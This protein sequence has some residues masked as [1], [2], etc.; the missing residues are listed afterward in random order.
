MTTKDRTMDLRE[1]R[2]MI[3]D[4]DPIC[5]AAMANDIE[6]LAGRVLEAGGAEEA[7]AYLK[8]GHRVDAFLLDVHLD[9][10]D[11]LSLLR[12]IKALPAY[13]HTPAVLVTS[14]QRNSSI[15][16]GVR[17]G[18]YF[19]LTKPTGSALL[20]AVLGAALDHARDRSQ[21]I[22]AL[23]RSHRAATLMESG[24]FVLRS[25][26]EAAALAQ[27]LAAVCP[28]P[29]AAS[30][31]LHELLINAVEHGNLGIDY[32]TKTRL[33]LQ[34]DWRN[35]VAKRLQDPVLAQRWVR[36]D[37]QRDRDVVEIAIEDRKST[38]LN[39]SHSQQSRM[40]S[41]A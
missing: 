11:G 21:Q 27:A 39:S 14:D 2:V 29:E 38:R 19:Y 40:P 8:A 16:A 36:V 10:G 37:Y 25:L 32:A 23:T 28:V 35:E 1:A 33:V 9:D 20:G 26:D 30:L 12:Q 13:Q 7:M 17:A 4:D 18:A 5:R 22:E 3:V 24:R 15:E 41:S 31:A 34:G 6:R